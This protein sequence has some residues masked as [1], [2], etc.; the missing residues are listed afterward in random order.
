[1]SVLDDYLSK[2]LAHE[3]FLK[4][5]WSKNAQLTIFDI[6]CCEGEDLIRYSRLFPQAQFHVFEPLKKNIDGLKDNIQRFAIRDVTI[7]ELALSDATGTS[8]FFLSSGHPKDPGTDPN[9]DYG[10]RSSSLFPPSETMKT[11]YPWLNFDEAQ[12]VRTE[13]LANYLRASGVQSIDLVHMDVQGAEL[14]VL[15]GAEELIS[16]ISALWLEVEAVEIYEG[17]PIK[18]E[19]ENFLAKARF[20]KILDT[21]DHVSGDQLW[22]NRRKKTLVAKA[23]LER[24]SGRIKQW[25]S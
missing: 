5:F 7:N 25:V 21:V 13:K 2:E 17:Q 12:E 23:F 20:I 4:R 15:G 10:K 6:G 24:I 3:R 9:W 14:K 1:M 8:K 19:V 22:L 16:G 18:N 11:Y